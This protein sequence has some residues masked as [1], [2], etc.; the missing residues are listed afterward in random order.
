ME[1]V[2]A[3]LSLKKLYFLPPRLNLPKK[4]KKASG[5]DEEQDPSM[6][7]DASSEQL[8]VDG[9]S[10]SEV[11]SEINFSYEYAQME[12]TMKALGRN[13]EQTRRAFKNLKGG[14]MLEIFVATTF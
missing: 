8:D 3:Y 9:D 11:S 2:N 1:W 5:E 14:R 13:G 4:K 10:S 6:K 12:V 7:N